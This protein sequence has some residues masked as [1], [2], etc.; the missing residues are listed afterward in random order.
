MRIGIGID[1]GGTYTDAAAYDFTAKEVL[2]TAKALTTRHDLSLGI[3]EALDKLPPGLVGRADLIS[4]STTLATNACVENRTGRAKLFFFGGDRVIIDRHG[5]EYGLPP[6]DAM[7]IQESHTTFS[8][9]TTGE[10]DWDFF[11]AHAGAAIA[12]QDGAAVVEIFAMRNG[13]VVEKAA[14]AILEEMSDVPVVCGHELFSELNCLQRA[15][16]ALVNAG[17][18][19]IVKRF[20]AAVK[21]AMRA[22]GLTQP[23]VIVRSDGSLMG[24]EFAEVRPVE[25][26]LSGP[27][28]SVM[29]CLELAG[30]ANGVVVDMGGT[31]TDIAAIRDGVPLGAEGGIRI[32]KWRTFVKGLSINTFGLGGDSAVH[33][34]DDGLFLE[35][36]RVVPVCIAASA[37][38]GMIGQLAE[39]M[40][41]QPRHTRYIHEFFL[42]VRDISASARYSDGERRFCDALADGPLIRK[43]AAAVL[44]KDEYN[45][46]VSRLLRD[47]VVQLCGLTPTDIMHL[48][49]DYVRYS[50]DASLLAA[51]FV[52][53]NI[54]VGMEELCELVYD[55]VRRKLYQNVVRT[56]LGHEATRYRKNGVDAGVDRLILDGHRAARGDTRGFVVP[57]FRTDLALIG[58]GAPI[59]IFL[60]EVADALGTRAVFPGHAD[61][62]NALGAVV[63]K[64]HA[65]RKIV[66]RADYDLAGI[67]GYTVFGDNECRTFAKL[68]EA[69]EFAAGE[70]EKGA[71]AEAAR[72]GAAGEITVTCALHPRESVTKDI[73][74]YLGA[75]AVAHAV[76]SPRL[77]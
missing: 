77:A 22:R 56:L 64:V 66:V 53:E 52:A 1:T 54:G 20:I 71:R 38:P 9:G 48:K 57:G 28:A 36:Y 15:S 69:E 50:R 43:A 45:F 49:G 27:A 17:L 3:A 60:P 7:Y 23:V 19:P 41:A 74:L 12:D 40:E 37:H 55:E 72:R 67:T 11:R 46:D 32:G 76:G 30:E 6:A 16:S 59:R 8:G 25:T 39:Q 73:S 10:V 34:R 42:L 70:A 33:Y 24:E 14:K 29:G 26:L 4:L 58:V 65:S 5:A 62:A 51:R 21:E 47:G 18:F 75:E 68:Q 61:V 31:T 63:G 13:A 2:G 35:E 44:G